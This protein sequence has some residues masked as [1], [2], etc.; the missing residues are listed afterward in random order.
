VVCVARATLT[1]RTGRPGGPPGSA[2][3]P[4]PSAA[5]V[6]HTHLDALLLWNP[7]HAGSLIVF[8]IFVSLLNFATCVTFEPLELRCLYHGASDAYESMKMIV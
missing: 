3:R 6:E 7:P 8:G 2:T 4:F 1:T 5:T